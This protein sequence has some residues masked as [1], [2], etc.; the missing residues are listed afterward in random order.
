MKIENP[1]THEICYLNAKNFHPTEIYRWI[2]EVYG[3]R[4][5]YEGNMRKWCLLH[6]EGR[7]KSL[8]KVQTRWAPI[9]GHE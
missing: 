8:D 4:A 6:K 7:T 3:E 5:T 1:T 9:F 2:V